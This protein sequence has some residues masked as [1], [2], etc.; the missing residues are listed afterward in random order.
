MP[1][2]IQT[3]T[4]GVPNV[5]FDGPDILNRMTSRRDIVP[6]TVLAIL[7]A[8]TVAIQARGSYDSLRAQ[9]HITEY[10]AL[11]FRVAE[12]SGTLEDVGKN[13]LAAGIA[14]GDAPVSVDGKELRGAGPLVH[15]INAHRAGDVVPVLVTRNGQTV[16]AEVRLAPLSDQPLTVAQWVLVGV[17]DYLTPW[18][19]MAL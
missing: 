10:P 9:L 5:A 15:A 6:L 1:R 13:A 16:S 12:P 7:F 2:F 4:L 18:F 17:L 8:I 3:L 11:P 14:Q 19:C